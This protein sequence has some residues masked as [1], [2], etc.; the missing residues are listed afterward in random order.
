MTRLLWLP[1]ALSRWLTPAGFR[2]EL[3]SGWETRGVAFPRSP[4]V[5][6]GHHTATSA[7]AAGNL[8]TLGILR[9]GRSDLPGPLCQVGVG[10]DGTAY[11][12]AAGKAN[13]AGQGAWRDTTSSASTVGIEVEHPGTGTWSAKQLL[14]FDLVAAALLE[15]LGAGA[16]SYCGHREWAL[17]AG[18]KVDPGGVDLPAQRRRLGKLLATGPRKAAAVV[19]PTTPPAPEAKMLHVYT[20]ADGA[21]WFTDLVTRQRTASQEEK[22][23]RIALFERIN[24]VRVTRITLTADEAALL[25]ELTA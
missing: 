22:A 11:V 6:I 5:V 10:R 16:L 9:D 14:A 2:V 23:A 17:P 24:G 1:D 18:R 21:D 4:L 19:R 8:P 7:G 12:I 20:G 15:R 13:H 25:P 3:V